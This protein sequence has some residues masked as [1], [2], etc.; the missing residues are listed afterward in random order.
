M[1]YTYYGLQLA[2]LLYCSFSQVDEI[3]EKL[4]RLVCL[5]EEDRKK[6]AHLPFASPHC[7]PC[8]PLAHSPSP[9]FFNSSTPEGQQVGKVQEDIY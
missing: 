8:T 9:P 4:D 1:F 7:P 5:Y 3:E 6:F 2:E